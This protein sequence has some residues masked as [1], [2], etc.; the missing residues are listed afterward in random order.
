MQWY[1]VIE[2]KQQGPVSKQELKGLVQSK[3]INAQTLVWREGMAEW[4]P[5]GQLVGKN[6]TQPAAA[7]TSLTP[8]TQSDEAAPETTAAPTAQADG[9]TCTECG[10][11]FPA[12]EI[13]TYG[14]STVC[15]EC[16]PTFI[17][18][19]KEGVQTTANLVYAGFWIRLVAKFIDGIIL[20]IAQ[21]AVMLAGTLFLGGA[22]SEAQSPEAAFGYTVVTNLV[23]LVLAAV[24]TTWFLGRFG[25]TPG[26]MVFRLKVVNPEGGSISYLRALGRHFAEMLSGMILAIGYIM[27]AFDSEKRTLHDRICSTRVVKR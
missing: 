18:K 16:K 17:Q 5:L 26:K 10:R 13:I 20:A 8:T 23:Y 6:D 27:A 11:I 3:T 21:S 1:Y 7:D 12:D 25:A 19:I 2:G 14:E 9:V 4:Q 24:Y 22:A 15:A